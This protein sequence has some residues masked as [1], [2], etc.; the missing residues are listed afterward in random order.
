MAS[1]YWKLELL[2]RLERRD[3]L[4]FLSFKDLIKSHNKLFDNADILQS[5]IVQLEIQTLQ[6]KQENADLQERASISGFS[7]SLSG[8]FNSDKVQAFEQKIY[9]LQ[10]E[11]TV[12]H[13]TK[14]ENAQ[15][16]IELN[17]TITKKDNDLSFKEAKLQDSHINLECMK[18][19]TKRLESTIMEL[20]AT[21]QML[22]DELQALQ[23]AYNS[24]EMKYGR[25]QED[26]RE[27]VERW[28]IKKA[29]DADAMNLEN[30]QQ[31]KARQDRLR[32]DLMEAAKEPVTLPPRSPMSSFDYNGDNLSSPSFCF[33][34]S[35]P[36]V[37]LHKVNAHDGE[38]N[39]VGFSPNGQFFAT[40]GSDKLV[41]LWKIDKTCEV[42]SKIYGCNAGV[43]SIEIDSQDKLI[44]ASSND[45]ACRVWTYGDGRQRHTLTGHGNKVTSARFFLDSTK[46]VSGS[47]DR[48]LKIWDLK[49]RACSRTIF[50]GSSCN[51]LVTTSLAST[52]IISGHF[53]KRIRFW[54]SRSDTSSNEI[55]LSGRITSLSISPDRN[56]LLAATRGD[57]LKLINLRMSQVSGTLSADGL[58]IA[59]DCTRACF[60]ADGNYAACGSQDGS[61]FI[62]DTTT[63]KT[64]KVLK[65]NGA[66]VVCCGWHPDG[67]S[68]VSCDRNKQVIVWSSM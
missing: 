26:N 25:V 17:K 7:Y 35:I 33:S 18:T 8:T 44:L 9:K 24:L 14:G 16:V 42:I 34:T 49:T 15:K 38:V 64:E 67:R 37:P 30:E 27:L 23:L 40:G 53:D 48:T 57:A 32:R 22:K 60:S 61:I 28:M 29:K 21:N 1:N 65:S 63:L 55:V 2:Q 46:V 47:H 12:L 11:L 43:T 6:M 51:D 45:F 52:T 31:T 41:K 68:F 13:R 56:T 58:K 66:A 62:W 39:T 10:E 4:E 54:D 5:K 19:E 36:S 50:A 59:T 3:R 20:E